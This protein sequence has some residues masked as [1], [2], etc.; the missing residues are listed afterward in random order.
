[1]TIHAAKGL[2][3]PVV[4]IVGMEE[5]LFPSQLSLNAREDL[6]EERRLFYVALT[7]AKQKALLSFANTRYRWGTL[8][9]C[10]P[11]RFLE[12]IDVKYI[13]KGV[14]FRPSL[15]NKGQNTDNQSI[16]QPTQLK[17][18]QKTKSQAVV[19][20]S[21]N[22]KLINMDNAVHIPEM[23]QSVAGGLSIIK[24]MKVEH[25]RFGMGMVIQID[26]VNANIK[27]IVNFNGIGQKQLLLKY[28]KLK[29]IT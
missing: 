25:Q 10:E 22:R 28:A 5:N 21:A 3:F 11:S 14:A 27:A 7:R 15:S 24:G 19:P 2:E 23:D 6:E 12:E 20:R 26:G 16:T 8:I 9:H 1:M 17:V 4:F 29:I 18:R 13:E